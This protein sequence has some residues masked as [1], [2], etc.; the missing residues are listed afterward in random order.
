MLHDFCDDQKQQLAP[1]SI[2]DLIDICWQYRRCIYPRIPRKHVLPF[3]VGACMKH[4]VH[5]Q[6]HQTCGNESR[7]HHKQNE[8]SGYQNQASQYP[9]KASHMH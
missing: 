1:K 6:E 4:I 2:D 3:H 9:A 5:N 7:R 8:I